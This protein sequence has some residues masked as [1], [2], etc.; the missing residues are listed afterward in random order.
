MKKVLVIAILMLYLFGMI[1]FVLADNDAEIS[2]DKNESISSGD[3][4]RNYDDNK[5]VTDD[6]NESDKQETNKEKNQAKIKIHERDRIRAHLDSSEVPEN[7][8][9]TGESLKCW[10]NGERTMTITAGKSG[11][12]IIQ[13]KGVNASTDVSLYKSE[14]K[15][16]GVFDNNTKRILSPE[17]VE[18]KVRERNQVRFEEHNITL[19]EDGYYRIQSEKRARLFFLFNVKER[20]RTQIDAG[21]GEIVRKR[22][23][24]WGFLA[25]DTKSEPLL[26]ESCATVSSN[27]TDICC[28]RKGYDAWDADKADCVFSE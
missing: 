3:N 28:I 13:V 17:Q 11:N 14:G 18:E 1:A 5:S 26:G 12:T 6:K 4:D 25:R 10:L 16:Y 27:S 9:K 15:L 22:N 24:W 23:S 8:T 21:T 20:V 2:D 19:D 7:C